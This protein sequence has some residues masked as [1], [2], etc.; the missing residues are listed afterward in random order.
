MRGVVSMAKKANRTPSEEK[1]LKIKRTKIFKDI[2]KDLEEQLEI[3]GVFGQFYSDLIADYMELWVT[4]TL[5]QE[6]IQLRGVSV[7]YNNGGGQTGRKK[8]ESVDQLLKVN[9]QMLKILSDLGIKTT[10]AGEVDDL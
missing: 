6:D 5:L 10:T 1:Y 3:N 7:E 8:N 4:K 2:K 9:A